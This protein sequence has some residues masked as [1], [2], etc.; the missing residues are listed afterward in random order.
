MSA[1]LSPLHLASQ[2]ETLALTH[3]EESEIDGR[4]EA[5]DDGEDGDET[6]SLAADRDEMHEWSSE[7]EDDDALDPAARLQR[8]EARLQRA[9]EEL[10]RAREEI[11]G[12]EVEVGA[13]G[14][15][16]MPPPKELESF[17]PDEWSSDGDDEDDEDEEEGDEG[18]EFDLTCHDEDEVEGGEFEGDLTCQAELGPISPFLRT[19]SVAT[20]RATTGS[21][22]AAPRRAGSLAPLR[23]CAL[24]PYVEPAARSPRSSLLGL[25][26]RPTALNRGRGAGAAALALSLKRPVPPKQVSILHPLKL[27][28]QQAARG[29]GGLPPWMMGGVTSSD[30]ETLAPP[31]KK[32]RSTPVPLGLRF[33]A[34]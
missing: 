3:G 7:E 26:Y 10:R 4:S 23:P 21:T 32:Q 14:R 25:P 9:E 17:R 20:V 11:E 12:G 29:G 15:A 19:S 6:S 30:P 5:E 33:P 28:A 8:V 13:P 34:W 27:Q 31:R 16:S 18:G 1:A 22:A 24:A 2:V